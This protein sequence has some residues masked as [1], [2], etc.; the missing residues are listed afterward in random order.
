VE[1]QVKRQINHY[2]SYNTGAKTKVIRTTS[3]LGGQYDTTQ[4]D[5]FAG[6]NITT[7]EQFL[8]QPSSTGECLKR[9]V[10]PQ[11][12]EVQDSVLGSFLAV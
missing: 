2:R 6:K 7:T 12:Y 11:Y 1:K 10:V 4:K 5:L 9:P 3:N 8:A